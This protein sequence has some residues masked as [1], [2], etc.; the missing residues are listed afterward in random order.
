MLVKAHGAD[1]QY[2]HGASALSGVD[3]VLRVGSGWVAEAMCCGGQ[4]G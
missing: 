3:E 1:V 4:D 2:K